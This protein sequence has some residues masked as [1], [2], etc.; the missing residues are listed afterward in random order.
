M[1]LN[2]LILVSVD[3]HVVEPGNMFDNH[4]TAAQ[5][6]SAPKLVRYKDGSDR[7]V[8]G[9]IVI[10]NIGMN[11]VAGRPP[12]EYGFEPSSLEGMRRGCW[13]VDARID[14]MN[15]N[16]VLGSLNFGSFV[17]MDGNLFLRAP[18]KK[19][20]LMHLKAYNDWHIGEWCGAYPGRFIPMAI[21]PLW[22]IGESVAELKRVVAKG[23]HAISF[24]DNPSAR[25]LPSVHAPEWEPFWKACADHNIMINCH[26]GT[27]NMPPHPSMDFPIEAW[28]ICMPIAIALGA[29]DWLHL[30]ALRRYPLR[31]ALTEGGIGWIPYFLE[32]A[33]F[34]NWRH[35][36][37]T[38]SDLAPRSPATC[39]A[40]ISMP[41]CRR[42]IRRAEPRQ[43]RRRPCVLR[44]RLPALRLSVA[45][46]AGSIL[47]RHPG[48][49]G[50]S[51]QQDHA[52]ERDEG[53]RL[54]SLQRAQP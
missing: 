43:D 40:S 13:D 9:D 37:W 29:A 8:Y 42:Q 33:D 16:G 34:T 14:D 47:R 44:V 53:L 20:A 23:C 21:M 4:L 7:W 26:I 1:K 30:E 27:G 12:E 38:N 39:S 49:D 32:R 3:D 22:D 51:G 25:K 6:A 46:L 31:I 48:A 17:G 41:V 50:R 11:A 18:D 24:P 45:E 15:A 2:D 35:H 36:A 19:S 5:K 28:T 54:R 52:L 10:S